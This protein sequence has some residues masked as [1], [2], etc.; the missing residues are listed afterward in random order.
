MDPWASRETSAPSDFFKRLAARVAAT[1]FTEALGALGDCTTGST[2]YKEGS[3]AVIFS[4]EGAVTASLFESSL[5]LQRKQ[6][7]R[8]FM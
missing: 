2:S 1:F 4:A 3:S 5:S 6:K 8:D 7:E